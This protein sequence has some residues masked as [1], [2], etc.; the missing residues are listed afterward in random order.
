M[1]AALLLPHLPTFLTSPEVQLL[2]GATPQ[3]ALSAALGRK[4]P[5]PCVCPVTVSVTPAIHGHRVWAHHPSFHF[6]LPA[7]WAGIG[8]HVTVRASATEG[9]ACPGQQLGGGTV[10]L[11]PVAYT[12]SPSPAPCLQVEP[13][14]SRSRPHLQPG[15][16]KLSV[17]VHGPGTI[18]L[19]LNRFFFF[20]S[21]LLNE[22]KKQNLCR[23]FVKQR[24]T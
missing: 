9:R 12:Q 7:G 6:I 14:P 11:G 15:P 17:T 4:V 16:Q 8:A 21:K 24:R 3:P 20:S 18:G 23:K 5:L 10:A 22:R 13:Q 2:P 1:Q 19:G